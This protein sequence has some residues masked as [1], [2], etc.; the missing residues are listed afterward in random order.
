MGHEVHMGGCWGPRAAGG[1]APRHIA[2]AWRLHGIDREA[3]AR[4]SS[5][6]RPRYRER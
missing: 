5:T 2:L 6:T 1:W 4:G 3:R